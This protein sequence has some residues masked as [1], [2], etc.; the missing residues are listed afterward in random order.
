MKKK[1]INLIVFCMAV[2]CAVSFCLAIFLSFPRGEKTAVAESRNI[3]VIDARQAEEML[4]FEDDAKTILVGTVS[5]ARWTTGGDLHLVIPK[6]V[7]TIKPGAGTWR[8]TFSC[9]TKAR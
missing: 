1:K 2:V 8:R 7:V 4:Q 3:T 9:R 6:S 5:D